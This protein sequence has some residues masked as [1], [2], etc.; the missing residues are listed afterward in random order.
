LLD[1]AIAESLAILPV[2][3]D[4]LRRKTNETRRSERALGR[5]LRIQS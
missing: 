4:E 2:D 1:M 5:I 3:A